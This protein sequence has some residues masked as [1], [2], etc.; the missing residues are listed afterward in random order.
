MKSEGSSPI[1]VCF[2]DLATYKP[3]SSR[4][5]SIILVL[6]TYIRGKDGDL[7]V[8]YGVF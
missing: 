7:H 6:D 2:I 1:N 8:C 4:I 3:C 5:A